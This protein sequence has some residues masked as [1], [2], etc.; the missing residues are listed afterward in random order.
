MF[1][2]YICSIFAYMKKVNNI[3]VRQFSGASVPVASV[4]GKILIS[5]ID[6][7]KISKAILTLTR[8]NPAT[9]EISQSTKDSLKEATYR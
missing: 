1:W 2:N 8:E 4:M 6:S 7:R 5:S 9:V 3:Q